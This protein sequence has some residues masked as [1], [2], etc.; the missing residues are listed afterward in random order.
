MQSGL[1]FASLVTSAATNPGSVAP[2]ARRAGAEMSL[3]LSAAPL[4]HRMMSKLPWPARETQGRLVRFLVVGGGTALVQVAVIT[5]LKRLMNETAAF[6]LSWVMSTAVHYLANRFWA[7]PST[8]HDA[9][10]QFS[11]YLL[12]I[13]VS[14]A[15]NL[16][17]YK[18]C[19]EALGMSVE[20]AT[21]WAIPPSTLVV[22]LLLNYHVFRAAKSSEPGAARE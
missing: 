8:R 1:G 20:W 22:F 17:A 14:Y 4:P 7:L 2:S 16:V 5:V 9:G 15:I 11:E 6:S 18:V 12:T 21:L 10:R 19:R 13:A 3:Q